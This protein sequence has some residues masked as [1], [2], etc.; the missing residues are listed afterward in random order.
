[1]ISLLPFP[2]TDDCNC[3]FHYSTTQLLFS[4]SPISF[5]LLL[6]LLL[7]THTLLYIFALFIDDNYNLLTD[8]DD[9][10]EV[11]KYGKRI[12]KTWGLWK[13]RKCDVRV[14]EKKQNKVVCQYQFLFFF[15]QKKF[16]R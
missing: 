4:R 10:G 13:C 12:K 6:F 11:K 1:M 9:D 8:D 14:V 3:Y 7:H 16:N 2:A 15:L 5:P